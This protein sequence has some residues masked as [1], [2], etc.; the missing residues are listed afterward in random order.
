VSGAGV[1]TVVFLPED[2]RPRRRFPVPSFVRRCVVPLLLLVA[3]QAGSKGGWWSAAVLPAPTAVGHEFIVLCRSGQ[4]PSNLL[5]SLRR[6]A[7][8]ATLGITTGLALGVAVGLWRV[9]EEALDS[10]LQ[11]MRTLPYLVMLPLFVLWFGIGELPKVL[12]IA[13][14]T[15]LPMYLNTVSGVRAVDERLLEMGRE[16]GLGRLGLIRTVV[17]PGAMPSI[18]TGLRY[19]AGVSWLA[20]VVAEQINAQSGLGAL[21]ANAESLFETNVLIVCVV[22]YAALGLITDIAVRLLERRL[23]SWRRAN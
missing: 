14:G 7:L 9:A 18:L 23:L 6:V 4:L 1:E 22:L 10:T 5:V 19:S 12:I 15:A 17:L 8:G 20:L 16:F 3:W 21:I 2:D 11:M 13:L